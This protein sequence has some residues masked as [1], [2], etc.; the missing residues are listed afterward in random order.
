MKKL[1]L[2]MTFLLATTLGWAQC[3]STEQDKAGVQAACMDYIQAF[4]KADTTIAYRSVHPKLQKRGFSF[5]QAN[6]TY[7]QQLEMPFP[8]LI[9]LA[10]RWNKDGKQANA[11]SVQ[12]VQI[13][14]ICDK[15]ASAKVTAVWGIDYI[16]LV[17]EDGKWWV[18]NVLWQS[19]PN[20][21]K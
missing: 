21:K 20:Q 17:K 15:T 11:N 16:H 12:T 7:S 6:Q 10:K 2:S 14:D 19:L 8:A 4:Y 1:F 13:L 5:S 9:S 3:V 18:M